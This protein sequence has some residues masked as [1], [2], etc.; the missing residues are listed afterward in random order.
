[1]NMSVEQQIQALRN[2]YNSDISEKAKCEGRLEELKKK[3][4]EIVAKCT[5]KGIKPE[6][7]AD[8]K[9]AAQAKVNALISQANQMCGFETP[10]Q[11]LSNNAPF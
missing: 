4:D 10:S 9:S 11:Q 8:K 1:M 2:K 5:T 3:Q 6:E 7:L